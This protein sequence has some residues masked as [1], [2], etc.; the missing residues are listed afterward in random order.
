MEIRH[1]SEDLNSCS[2][3]SECSV[4]FRKVMTPIKHLLLGWVEYR[5]LK[6]TEHQARVVSDHV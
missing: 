6:S 2:V 3:F 1:G 5:K 4:P